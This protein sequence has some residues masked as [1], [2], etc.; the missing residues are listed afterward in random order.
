MKIDKATYVMAPD[1]KNTRFPNDDAPIAPRAAPDQADGPV[2]GAFQRS[3][4]EKEQVLARNATHAD[5]ALPFVTSEAPSAAAERHLHHRHSGD[6]LRSP[7]AE[8]A[9]QGSAED[10]GE[11]EVGTTTGRMAPQDRSAYSYPPIPE[12]EDFEMGQEASTVPQF[13]RAFHS[14]PPP[15]MSDQQRFPRNIPFGT[16]QRSEFIDTGPATSYQ[17]SPSHSDKKCKTSRS[18]FVPIA[19]ARQSTDVFTTSG[20]RPKSPGLFGS[21]ARGI[22]GGRPMSLSQVPAMQLPPPS[23]DVIAQLQQIPDM[24]S[25]GMSHLTQMVGHLAQKVNGL[26]SRMVELESENRALKAQN[27]KS[28]APSTGGPVGLPF[29]V[30]GVPKQLQQQNES[31]GG[32]SERLHP[33]TRKKDSI[34][35][36]GEPYGGPLYK[37]TPRGP[38]MLGNMFGST[39]PPQRPP[40]PFD[41]TDNTNSGGFGS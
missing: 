12:A 31:F 23:P 5:S 8:R 7:A 27:T 32:N 37:P 18:G 41:G 28:S 4:L 25:G 24:L 3:S 13:E 1:T 34:P 15:A 30:V 17:P 22:R 20:Q 29:G 6:S 2:Y 26:E 39:R 33:L 14:H 19:P 40:R 35:L 38:S 10:L 11:C 21:Q 36:P 9:A 16:P